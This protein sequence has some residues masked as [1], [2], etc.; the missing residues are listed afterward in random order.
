MREVYI[1]YHVIPYLGGMS[2]AVLLMS[3]LTP[4]LIFYV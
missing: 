4:S 3:K 2:F 1:S